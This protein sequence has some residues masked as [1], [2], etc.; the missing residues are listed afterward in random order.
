ML[1]SLSGRL[2]GVCVWLQVDAVKA[3]MG[4]PVAGRTAAYT[5]LRQNALVLWV[6]Y[7]ELH[8]ATVAAGAEPMAVSDMD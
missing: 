6:A 1:A 2:D 4:G 5:A 7:N 8:A 3:A